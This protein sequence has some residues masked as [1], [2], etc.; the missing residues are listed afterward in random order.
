[1]P[2]FQDEISLTPIKKDIRSYSF[3]VFA[4]DFW[5]G[6]AISL[7]SIPQALAYSIVLG[8]PPYCGL[9]STIFGTAICA[10]FGSSRHLVIGPNNTTVLLVQG[11]TSTI[12][13]KYYPALQGAERSQIALEIMAAVLLLMGLF[14][15]LSGVMK[16]GRVIQF[17]SLPV[18]VGYI[19]GSSFAISCEQLFPFLGIESLGGEVTLFEKMRYLLTHLRDIHPAAALVGILSLT[20]LL[21]LAKIRLPVP[22]SLTMILLVT[23]LVYIFHLNTI[24]D[25]AGKTLSVI[26]DAGRIEAV[27]PELSLP[28]F[29]LRLF[30]VLLPISFAIA[31]ISMLE[32]TAI[33]KSVAA[34]SGQ[35]LRVNQELFGL[36][37]ANFF[38]SF[39]GSLPASGSIS[40]T[41]VNYES[42]GKTRFAAVFSAIFVAL[43]VAFF[44]WLIQYIPLATLAAL[45]VGTALR[46][47]D[48][49][50]LAL[51]LRATH[52]DAFVL[53]ATF[54]SCI[55]F[56]L[57]IAFYTGVALSIVLYLRKA[58]T[59]VVVEYTYDEETEGL[60][61]MLA[62]ERALKKKI[63]IINIEGE[64]F[65]G[66]VDIFQSALK[67]IAEDDEETRVFVVRLKHVRDLDATAA[68]ALKQLHDFLRKNGRHLVVASI[69][70]QVWQVLENAKLIEY[71]GKEN[72]YLFD[73]TKPY[74]AI[75]QALLR[76]WKLAGVES[77]EKALPRVTE[78]ITGMVQAEEP[79]VMDRVLHTLADQL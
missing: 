7:L 50:Q 72:L 6:L 60:R 9:M 66:A 53:V 38:L 70:P 58:A 15:I 17:A 10:L 33:A 5:A 14:Q 19:L 29:E 24:P 55:F 35:R 40:R 18:I 74:H 21:T 34:Q 44:G 25:H 12:L 20:V 27:V 42:G 59:P 11:A 78:E 77:S 28:L 63:R 32:T 54:L 61:P 47:V 68:T 69:P 39:F 67:A 51:C 4:R 22:R 57:H 48:K 8:L 3:S 36:G 1:M 79:G 76:A 64:L 46:A 37:L 2:Y 26:G 52:S 16:L 13:Y 49:K 65:F 31:L 41:I 75:E 56:S 45:L 23:S 43:A 73:E 71:L 62:Q 30:N